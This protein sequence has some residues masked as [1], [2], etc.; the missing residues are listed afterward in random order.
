MADEIQ[1]SVWSRVLDWIYP[2]TCRLCG[3]L[4]PDGRALCVCC[5]DDLPGVR[6]AFCE[7]C[8]EVFPARIEQ[9]FACPNCRDRKFAFAFSR[10]GVVRSDG[11]MDLVHEFKYSRRIE[12]A[13]A[14]AG[15]AR[16]AFDEDPRLAEAVAGSWPLVPV[17]LHWRRHGWRQFNQAREIARPLGEWLGMPVIRALKRT[18]AT[19]TQTRLSRR[20]RQQNL[21][22]AFALRRDVSGWPGAV[23]VDDV[24]TTG[25]TVH[26]CARVLRRGGVQKVVVVT[27]MRG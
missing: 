11:A 14:L 3:D 27:V 5:A 7:Q 12:L 16:R 24:F 25:S 13:E 18:R 23:L 6:G 15:L 8:S 9:T 10:S 26:E 17:P 2:G 19:R 22:G 4:V 20:E 21:R 1:R